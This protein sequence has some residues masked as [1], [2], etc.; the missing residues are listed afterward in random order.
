MSIN[1]VYVAK[2]VCHA[3]KG[4]GL[5]VF[6]FLSSMEACKRDLHSK[7]NC[8][9]QEHK[10]YA[11]VWGKQNNLLQAEVKYSGK[12]KPIRGRVL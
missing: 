11:Q 9:L 1:T 7:Q 4:N 8:K 10:D 5:N 6:G 2:M 3:W 12:N